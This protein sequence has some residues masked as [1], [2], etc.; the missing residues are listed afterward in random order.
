MTKKNDTGKPEVANDK[1]WSKFWSKV[2]GREDPNGCWRWTGAHSGSGYAVIRRLEQA[3][4]AHRFVYEYYTQK[5]IPDDLV[6][7]HS[8]GTK[9][10]VN[11]SHLSLVRSS[12]VVKRVRTNQ[13][14]A[15]INQQLADEIREEYANGG[16]TQ[17]ELAER[18]NLSQSAISAI[19]V[20]IRW[21][22][23]RSA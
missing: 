20:G 18:Y 6:V 1:F 10:C 12:N 5:P 23:K 17:T 21:R 22:K 2:T 11:Q 16:V 9:D 13:P 7:T 4:Y 8:C 15:I 3:I 19:I 14:R